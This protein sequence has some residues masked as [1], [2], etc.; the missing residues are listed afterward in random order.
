MTTTPTPENPESVL[1]TLRTLRESI[2]D[3]NATELLRLAILEIKHTISRDIEP[4]DTVT[5]GDVAETDGYLRLCTV[6]E[7]TELVAETHD[8]GEKPLAFAH[9]MVELEAK[10][11]DG[12]L[13]SYRT[14][15]TRFINADTGDVIDTQQ[16]DHADEFTIHD[17]DADTEFTTIDHVEYG[18]NETSV[19]VESNL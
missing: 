10:M 18:I 4:S 13:P 15:T 8:L 7:D 11:K 9:S 6:D 16:Y 3:D 14:W 2:T 17:I 1:T 5:K 19:Y 12:E